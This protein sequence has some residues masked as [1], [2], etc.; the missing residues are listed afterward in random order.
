MPNRPLLAAAA[1]AAAL[2]V[3]GCAAP[4]YTATG[5]VVPAAHRATATPPKPSP[6]PQMD[7]CTEQVGVWRWGSG[8]QDA[9][10]VHKALLPYATSETPTARQNLALVL[11]V[12]AA[13]TQPIP[14]CADPKG[15]YP[16]FLSALGATA[17]DESAYGPGPA[18]LTDLDRALILVRKLQAEV[19]RTVGLNLHSVTTSP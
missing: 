14:R 16:R 13:R 10:A 17:A 8:G 2:T 6:S 1:L 3:A 19:G 18:A 9:R 12:Q 15:Y 11:A 5:P 7:P 4:R